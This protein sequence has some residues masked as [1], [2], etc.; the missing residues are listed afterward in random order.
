MKALAF[1]ALLPFLYLTSLLPFRLLYLLSDV[2]YVVVFRLVGYRRRVVEQ[3]LRRAFPRKTEAEIAALV[4]AYYHFLCDVV[5]ETIK[6]LT[7]S[8]RSLKKRLPFSDLSEVH[9]H[10][11]AGRRIVFILGHWGCWELGGLSISVHAPQQADII[12]RPLSNPYFDRLMKHLRSRLGNRLI[13]MKQIMRFLITHQQE[14][15]ITIFA[16]DQTP[17]PQHAHWMWFLNQETGVF[18]GA[19]KISKKF[20]MP[21]FYMRV[22]KLRRGYYQIDAEL[23]ASHPRE[24]PEGEISKRFMRKLEADIQQQ[25][26]NWLWS[27]KR[28]KHQRPP[29]ALWVDERPPAPIVDK[30]VDKV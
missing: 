20:D 23:L 30:P 9:A 11:Q 15:T 16:A 19:D 5:L 29:Q 25:P 1:Y 22:R 21:V 28:W 26:A 24:L 13:P 2:M 12:Y 10:W 6:G 27:H 18:P 3:N 14:P 17:P 4:R 8:E 7:I